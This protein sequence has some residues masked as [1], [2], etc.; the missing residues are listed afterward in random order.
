MFKD[1]TGQVF[2]RL[3]VI[4]LK[5]QN[6]KGKSVWFCVCLCGKETEVITAQL[7]NG[8]IRSCGCYQ[9]DAVI[10]HGATRGVGSGI[11]HPEYTAYQ[12]AKYRCTNP[13]AKSWDNYGGRGI[14]FRF[15][16]FEE[17]IDALK[18]SDNPSGMRPEG[19]DEN[20][21]SLYSLDRIDNDGHYEVKDGVSNIRW[22]T[23]SQQIRNQRGRSYKESEAA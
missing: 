23:R 8:S 10:T 19:A 5:G 2:E 13:A 18:T 1:L 14:E 15:N 4:K 20:G 16:S 17:F 9:L 7:R 21:Y 11:K 3:T 22:A 6:E 12:T